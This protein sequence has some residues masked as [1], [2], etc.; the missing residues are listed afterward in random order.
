M[1]VDTGPFSIGRGS[2]RSVCLPDRACSRNHA[3]I[4]RLG[5]RFVLRDLESANGTWVNGKRVM[6]TSLHDGDE[7]RIG[8]T[9]FRFDAD[10]A[11]AR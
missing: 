7:L 8:A 5:A 10:A 4:H 11:H 9:L 3:E 1:Q 2:D 6:E